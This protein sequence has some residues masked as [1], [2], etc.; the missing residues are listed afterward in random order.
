MGN[1]GDVRHR[2]CPINYEETNPF[3]FAQGFFSLEQDWQ[4]QI[5]QERSW[6][7]FSNVIKPHTAKPDAVLCYKYNMNVNEQSFESEV[8]PAKKVELEL[9]ER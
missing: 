2:I 1:W 6:L 4:S 8:S 3:A 5:L 9:Y 7:L